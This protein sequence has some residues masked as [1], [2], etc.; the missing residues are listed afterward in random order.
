MKKILI[1]TPGYLPLLGGMEEQCYQIAKEFTSQGYSVD[2]LTEKTNAGFKQDEVMGGVH[3]HRVND[4]NRESCLF[5]FSLYWQIYKF[6]KNHNDYVFIIIRTFTSY[7]LILGAM[8]LFKIIKTPTFITADTGGEIDELT[9][10]LNSKI[11]WLYRV[12]FNRHDYINSICRY[13]YKKYLEIGFN[14]NKLT[15]I[16]NG[17][18]CSKYE[19]YNYP[20]EVRDFLFIAQLKKEKGLYETIEAF[21]LLLD[22]YPEAKLYIAGDGP[23]FDNIKEKIANNNNENSITMMG[24]INAEQKDDFFE[25]GQCLVLPSYSEG[26]GL[27]YYEAA[28]HKRAIIATDVGDVKDVF[29]EQIA[30][31]KKRDIKDLYDK[32]LFSIEKLDLSVLNYDK[33]IEMVDI[34]KVIKEFENLFD[35]SKKNS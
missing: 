19:S 21:V 35:N 16:Y 25:K 1:V 31:S 11:K 2:V 10:I 24:R 32:M 17:I 14:K 18:D 6:F 13:N 7:G 29:K 5:I 27:V 4:P 12:L 8:K 15:K 20:D 26:F 22:R 28:L 9:P 33:I 30:V 3:V 34:K 23:E